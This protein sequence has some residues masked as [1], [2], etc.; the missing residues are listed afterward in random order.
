MAEKKPVGLEALASIIKTKYKR[1]DDIVD[2]SR[3][4]EGISSGCRI[5]D[6]ICGNYGLVIKGRITELSGSESSGKSSLCLQTAS[7]AMKKGIAVLYLDFEQTFDSNYA[8]ALG[9]NLKDKSKFMVLQPTTL[10]DGMEYLRAFESVA[11]VG[12]VLIVIDSIATAI[13]A[14]LLEQAGDQEQIGLHAQ[15]IGGLAKYLNSVWCGK[16]QAYILM[17]NQIRKSISNANPYAPKAI[18]AT[19]AGFGTG[20]ESITTTGGTQLRYLQSIRILLDY[21][22]KIETGDYKDGTLVREGNYINAKVI[23][24]KVAP[25]FKTAKIAIVYGKGTDDSFAILETLKRHEVI[26]NAGSMFYYLDSKDNEFGTGLSFKMKGKDA[27]YEKLKE[28]QY[29][30]DMKLNYERILAQ[31]QQGAVKVEADDEIE[32]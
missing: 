10:E 6:E 24:N 22:G 26:T 3:S 18:K 31:E 9:I 27:F 32:E 8:T 15:R 16:L 11:E 20:D 29:Q 23:K 5:L 17:V 4:Y 30:E 14:K 13:P 1:E 21:A 12:K 7:C 19:G 28:K 2:Y 25:P